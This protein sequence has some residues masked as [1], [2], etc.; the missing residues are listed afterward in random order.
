MTT[1]PYDESVHEAVAR[2]TARRKRVLLAFLGLL[3]VPIA[4]GAYAISKA[5]T[6]IERLASDVTPIVTSRVAGEITERVTNDISTRTEPL[7]RKNVAREVTAAIEPRLASVTQDITHLQA[8]TQK[9]S[10][11]V[12]SVRPQLAAVPE[13]TNRL[14]TF[15]ANQ[16]RMGQENVTLARQLAEMNRQLQSLQARVKALEN[17]KQIPR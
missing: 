4:I 5:P 14:T 6:E 17:P 13:L 12:E 16:G 3:L 9:T 1:A 11:L 10:E 8:T 15:N 2:E 7:I